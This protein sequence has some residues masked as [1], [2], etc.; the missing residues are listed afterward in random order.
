MA[1]A[2]RRE[3]RCEQIR[4]EGGRGRR[5]REE[6]ERRRRR[7][8]MDGSFKFIFIPIIVDQIS[9]SIDSIRF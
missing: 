3:H 2:K 8:C 1:L 4:R 7:T 9:I 5:G 6:G